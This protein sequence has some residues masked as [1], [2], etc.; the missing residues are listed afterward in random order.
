MS[1]LTIG[2]ILLFTT[3]VIVFLLIVPQWKEVGAT[4]TEIARL[5]AL[6]DELTKL[7][8][9]RDLLTREYNAISES[10]LTKLH[11]IVPRGQDT[12]TALVDFES[13][14]AKNGLFLSRIDFS[15]EATQKGGLVPSEARLVT[16]MPV[17]LAVRANY[18]SLRA[19]LGDLEN[20]LRIFDVSDISFG[21]GQATSDQF[22][23][24]L[25]GKMYYRP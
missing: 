13:L 15:G 14:T 2:I 16:P 25:K 4:R 5:Q 3:A 24:S 1:R 21:G 18:G 8:E 17:S 19:F 22:E 11:G 12:G 23:I 6:N 20:M 7:A 9:Q 10:D